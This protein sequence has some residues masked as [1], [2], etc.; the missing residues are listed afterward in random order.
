MFAGPFQ[1]LSKSMGE[2]FDNT[3]GAW[4]MHTDVLAHGNQSETD[5]SKGLER[6]NELEM[7]SKHY[8]NHK[9]Q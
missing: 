2:I 6:M 3:M 8:L 9:R 1:H 5:H 4:L 7:Y